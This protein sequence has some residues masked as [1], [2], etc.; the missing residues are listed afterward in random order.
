MTYNEYKVQMA[1]INDHLR[2]LARAIS[3]DEVYYNINDETAKH[4]RDARSSLD[5]A[6]DL[7]WDRD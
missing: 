2:D 7:I 6:A 3:T 5:Q 1:R 4:I